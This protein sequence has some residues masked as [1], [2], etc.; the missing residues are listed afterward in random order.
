MSGPLLYID[1]D[2]FV[3]NDPWPYLSQFDGDMAAV[4]YNNAQLNSATLLINDTKNAREV[5]SRWKD[6]ADKRRDADHGDLEASGDNCDQGV[7]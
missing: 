3:H 2:A 4:F 6:L 1:V 7:L 5:L